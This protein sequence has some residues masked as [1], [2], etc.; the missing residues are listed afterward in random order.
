MPGYKAAPKKRKP[1]P[2]MSTQTP[3]FG[4]IEDGDAEEFAACLAQNPECI[5]ETNKNGWTPLHQAAFS[6]EL[7]M[8]NTLVEKGLD[9][10]A[11]CKD[12]DTPVH[13]AAC[14]GEKECVE[15]LAAAGAD[16]TIKDND[17]ETPYKVA[18]KSVKKLIKDLIA[19]AQGDSGEVEEAADAMAAAKLED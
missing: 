10:N 11:V 17:G 16:L 12:G 1:K 14:Q 5:K 19:K 7:A 13:Y 8:L 2:K 4:S 18:H 9:V 6:G 15:A 3:I